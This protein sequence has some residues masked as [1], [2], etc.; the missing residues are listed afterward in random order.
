MELA[1]R[2][3]AARAAAAA[4]ADRLAVEEDN[5]AAAR[6][7][8]AISR[9]KVEALKARAVAQAAELTRADRLS[10]GFA[11]KPSPRERLEQQRNDAS[12][13]EV[14]ALN[15]ILTRQAEARW[16]EVRRENGALPPEREPQDEEVPPAEQPEGE[17]LLPTPP[18][19]EGGSAPRTRSASGSSQQQGTPP[20]T[21][22]P[23]PPREMADEL[24]NKDKL[25]LEA[26]ALRAAALPPTPSPPPSPPQ[27]RLP[28]AQLNCRQT[29]FG[30]CGYIQRRSQTQVAMVPAE[31]WAMTPAEEG[32]QPWAPVQQTG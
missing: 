2:Q 32:L 22:P 10:K 16:C 15:V 18:A 19:A 17:E 12:R 6:W 8:V 1:G 29:G 3:H 13:A 4:E 5:Q 21:P 7:R 30:C 24:L 31:T 11:A 14:Y 20:L 9:A 26:A 27:R 28:A 23:S 25:W